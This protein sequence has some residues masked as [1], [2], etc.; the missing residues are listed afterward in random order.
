MSTRIIDPPV[1]LDF[2]D[3]RA[4]LVI[5]LVLEALQ[6]AIVVVHAADKDGL[7]D[8]AGKNPGHITWVSP[9]TQSEIK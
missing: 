6:R 5:T 7:L 2:R 8:D 1:R 4:Q 9:T 3:M